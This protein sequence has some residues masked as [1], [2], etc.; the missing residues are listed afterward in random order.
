[1]LETKKENKKRIDTRKRHLN[2]HYL[3]LSSQR[4][5]LDYGCQQR[6]PTIYSA[7]LFILSS[8]N[9]TNLLIFQILPLL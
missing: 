1:M 9:S 8:L 6:I 2:N 7:E 3:T 5:R 4:R